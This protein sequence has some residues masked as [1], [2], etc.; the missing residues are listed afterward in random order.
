MK[1]DIERFASHIDRSG[2]CWLWNGAQNG[3]GYGR[4]N[5]HGVWYQAHR[6]AWLLA[7]R[8]LPSGMV[9]NHLCQNKL[10]VRV[11]HLE[12]V[13]QRQNAQYGPMRDYSNIIRDKLGKFRKAG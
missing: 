5:L 6:L 9:L 12:C 1:T 7:G 8:E 13:T 10:C 11:E 4:V 3:R 2:E